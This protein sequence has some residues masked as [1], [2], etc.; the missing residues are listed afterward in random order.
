MQKV[1]ALLNLI[2]SDEVYIPTFKTNHEIV[3]I[4]IVNMSDSGRSK[5]GTNRV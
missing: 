1:Y 2:Q 4:L 3:K 5:V